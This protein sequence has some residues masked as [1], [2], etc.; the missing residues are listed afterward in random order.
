MWQAL[1]GSNPIK[2]ML[3]D[4]STWTYDKD[5]ATYLDGVTGEVSGDGYTSG[6]QTL[7]NVTASYDSSNNRL[8][9]DGDNPQWDASGGELTAA[10]AVFYL[11]TGTSSSSPI[12]SVWD[13][14][15][16]Q[17]ATNASFTLALAP[18]GL[19]LNGD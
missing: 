18:A 1:A 13:F 11:D 16:D 7:T 17:T 19:L 8:V 12:V 4:G 5:S 15:G 9:V 10:R 3:I 14:G 2:C 6:G